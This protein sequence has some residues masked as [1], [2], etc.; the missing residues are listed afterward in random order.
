VANALVM[1]ARGE[2]PVGG[3]PVWGRENASHLFA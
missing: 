2:I 1:L 3:V